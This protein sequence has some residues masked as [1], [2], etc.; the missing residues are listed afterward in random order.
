MCFG[1][2]FWASRLLSR[3]RFLP[4]LCY[5]GIR[6]SGGPGTLNTLIT[7]NTLKLKLTSSSVYLTSTL[8]PIKKKNQHENSSLNTLDE[9]NSQIFV[10][11]REISSL[12]P[13]LALIGI[14]VHLIM[15]RRPT[16]YIVVC[17]SGL[18]HDSAA[19]TFSFIFQNC[20]KEWR[21]KDP[22]LG[23]L[24]LSIIPRQFGCGT[25]PQHSRQKPDPMSGQQKPPGLQ[26]KTKALRRV[27]KESET[28]AW[29][30]FGMVGALIRKI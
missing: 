26:K 6:R 5:R 16:I 11:N 20:L 14:S 7:P 21:G 29:D 13:K 24:F 18:D 1:P 9:T 2:Q 15:T 30:R 12:D 25:P 19:T 8:F 10:A 22:H 27:W 17:C 3:G 28:V 23:L 4:L